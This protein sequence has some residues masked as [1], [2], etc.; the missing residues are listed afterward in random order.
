MLS[1][2]EERIFRIGD[3]DSTATDVTS[4]HDALMEA[5]EQI[6]ARVA[7]GASGLPTG[8]TDLDKKTGGLHKAELVIIAARPSMGKTALA[9]NIAEHVAITEQQTTLF[10]S[11]EMSRLELVQRMMCSQGSVNGEKYS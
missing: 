10:V 7:G 5:F 2:A 1:Q 4:A 9:A 8:F 11:L 6:D 3:E